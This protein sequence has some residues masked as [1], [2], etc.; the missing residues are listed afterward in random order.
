MNKKSSNYWYSAIAIQA[1]GVPFTFSPYIVSKR[2]SR[3]YVITRAISFLPLS[4]TRIRSRSRPS[5][6]SKGVSVDHGVQLIVGWLSSSSAAR[7][8]F[9]VRSSTNS[10]FRS[11]IRRS[12]SEHS[13]RRCE[14]CFLSSEL[15]MLAMNFLITFMVCFRLPC[16]ECS[17]NLNVIQEIFTS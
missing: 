17:T 8:K 10:F 9:R 15:M 12:L 1:T 11:E 13:E 16:Y 7:T 2:I 5:W 6:D 14:I 4:N 3:L